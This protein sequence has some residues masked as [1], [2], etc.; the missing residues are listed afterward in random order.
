MV[1]E[2]QTECFMFCEPTLLNLT[3]S[4]RE[5]SNELKKNTYRPNS[6]TIMQVPQAFIFAFLVG[7]LHFHINKQHIVYSFFVQTPK[8][9]GEIIPTNMY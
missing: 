9:A 8:I 2:T 7:V 5:C 3:H 6:W 1:Y 4:K